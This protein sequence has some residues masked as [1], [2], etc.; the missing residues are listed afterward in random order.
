MSKLA[1]IRVDGNSEIGM[2]HL[3][4]ELNIAK[5]LENFNYEVIFLTK[6][7]KEAISLLKMNNTKMLKIE[8]LNLN[9]EECIEEINSLIKGIHKKINII[10]IDLLY[11]YNNQKYLDYLKKYCEKLVV[12]TDHTSQLNIRP[13]IVFAFSQN[14]KPGWYKGI[15]Q[16]KYFT[17]LNNFPLGTEFK[18]VRKKKINKKIKNLLI[19]FGGTDAVNYSTRLIKMLKSEEISAKTKLII[20]P[21][22]SNINNQ[23]LKRELHNKI[24]IKR[25]V[26]DMLKYFIETDLC[27]C[28]AGNTLIELLTCGIPCIILPQTSRENEHASLLEKEKLIINLG[29]NWNEETLISVIHNLI[30]DY[31]KRKSLSELSQKFFDGQGLNR[32]VDIIIK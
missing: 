21:G 5:E 29:L 9:K 2:G 3:M 13:D 19:T 32:L 10:I 6:N 28:S 30:R 25:N 17:G 26:K 23:M 4:R 11:C 8:N 20:G 24:I 15:Q 18:N 16:T 12:L 22:F 14:Q 27:I 7:F 1:V 31:K